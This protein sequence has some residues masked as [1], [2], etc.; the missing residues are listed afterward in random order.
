[1]Y[2]FTYTRAVSL[3]SS[4]TR[5]EFVPTNVFEYTMEQ[6][7]MI[8]D[9]KIVIGSGSMMLEMATTDGEM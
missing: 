6:S 4:Y 3:I 9:E 8:V 5:K 7:Q 2:L 1:M